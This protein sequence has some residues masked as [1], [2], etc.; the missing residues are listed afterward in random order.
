M[1]KNVHIIDLM[2]RVVI[3]KDLL[4]DIIQYLPLNLSKNIKKVYVVTGPHVWDT[5]GK[6]LEEGLKS[7]ELELYIKKSESPTIEEAKQIISDAKGKSIDLIIG[8]GGGKSIDLAKYAASQISIPFISI[9]TSASHDGIASPF[10]SLKGGGWSTSVKAVEPICVI[11]DLEII[12]S[13]P[14]KLLIAGAGDAI[15]KLTAVSDWRLAHLLRN[16]YYG[17]YAAGLSLLSAKHIIKYSDIISKTDVEATRIVLEA[18]IS[19][20]VAIGI[21]GST[22]PASGSEHLFSHALDKIAPKP[23]LHGEQ[24]GVGTIMMSKLHRM[25]WKKVRR[26]LKKVGAPTTAKELGIPENIIIEALT[27]AHKIR[28][29]RYTILGDRGLTWEAAEK[30]ARDT[31]VIS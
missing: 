3:G 20:S 29:E 16:E 17:S 2:K 9:P 19:S 26:V 14:R 21:A 8:F 25:N 15:A 31:G 24:T 1:E 22:R 12:S 23:A 30:L 5:Y 27:I 28:P 4:K 11:A 6:K 13:S 18:L 7:K 10:A